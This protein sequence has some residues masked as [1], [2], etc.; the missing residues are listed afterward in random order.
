MSLIELY[1]SLPVPNGDSKKQF[2]A[3]AIEGCENCRI[4]VDS[5]GCPALLLSVFNPI[6]HPALKNFRFRHLNLLQNK[7]CVV[8]E[9]GREQVQT[10]TIITFTDSDRLLQEYFLRVSETFVK[11]FQQRQTAKSIVEA[12]VNFVEV[13]RLLDDSSKKTFQGLW[14]EL[15]LIARSSKPEILLQYWHQVP[16]EKFDFNAGSERIE[17]KSSNQFERVHTFSAEPLNPPADTQVIIAS[18]FAKANSAGVSMQNL[19]SEISSKVSEYPELISKLNLVVGRSLGGSLQE[20]LSMK[21][22][23][24]IAS[25]SLKL[26]RHQDIKRIERSDIPQEVFNVK[27][28]SDLSM[29]PS[30]LSSN[31][32]YTNRLFK[33]I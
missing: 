22:D 2:S 33:A 20:G 3:V 14:S 15:F 32:Q 12:I 28:K 17:V 1:D 10:F 24:E 26:Y 18:I 7:E 29:V 13:F 30:I 25:N 6:R 27:Y 11:V 23:Y 8:S 9:S 5:F 16:E 31:F 4:A 19:I 21:Y